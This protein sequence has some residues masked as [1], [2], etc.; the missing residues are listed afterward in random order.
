MAPK[1]TKAQLDAIALKNNTP[2][3]TTKAII[4][5]AAVGAADAAA[6]AAANLPPYDTKPMSLP[7][8]TAVLL[9]RRPTPVAGSI[10]M[11]C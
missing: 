3:A 10:Q 7:S 4:A 5:A 8:S 2:S 1:P 6:A 11:L 9:R